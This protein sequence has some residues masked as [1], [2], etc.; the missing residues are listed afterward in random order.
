MK[1]LAHVHVHVST[2]RLVLF[3]N[4]HICIMKM[5]SATSKSRKTPIDI[6]VAMSGVTIALDASFTNPGPAVI[7]MMQVHSIIS[8]QTS[9]RR[10]CCKIA[11]SF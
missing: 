5:I 1:G 4:L 8:K 2:L 6:K 7:I 9:L 3:Y 11:L 10:E